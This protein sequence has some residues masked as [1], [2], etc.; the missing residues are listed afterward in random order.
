MHIRLD[1]QRRVRCNALNW[2]IELRYKRHW[3]SKRYFT[4]LDSMLRREL[5]GHPDRALDAESL[6]HVLAARQRA[7]TKLTQVLSGIPAP[8]RRAPVEWPGRRPDPLGHT[9]GIDPRRRIAIERLCW[10]IQLARGERRW[11][12]AR[13]YPSLDALAEA[14]SEQ[15]VREAMQAETLPEVL[16]EVE[17]RA[18]ELAVALGAMAEALLHE[19]QPAV[20][21]RGEPA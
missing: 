13:Y 14:E 4:D 8:Y 20:S 6:A 21:E 17:R 5:D 3:R 18:T 7:H 12:A 10:T 2:I 19:A 15:D 11:E 16:A 1:E 9:A